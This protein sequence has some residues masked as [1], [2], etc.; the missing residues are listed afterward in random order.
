MGAAAS[1]KEKATSEVFEE[2]EIEENPHHVDVGD[3][4]AVKNMMDD[5]IV[6]FFVERKDFSVHYGW[7]NTKLLLM[8]IACAI[9]GASHFYRPPQMPEHLVV[10]GCVIAF[11][12]I[13]GLLFLY[14]T[15]IEGDILLRVSRKASSAS[16][17]LVKTEFPFTEENYIVT[18]VDSNDSKHPVREELYVGKFFD[19]EGYFDRDSFVKRI[20]AL[21]ARVEKQKAQ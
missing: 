13:H 8:V 21:V 14:A 11:F 1:A 7:D 10:L 12:L 6:E 15:L 3:Q 17:L 2:E 5:A 20:D 18:M 16:V 9:A 4:N 19:A